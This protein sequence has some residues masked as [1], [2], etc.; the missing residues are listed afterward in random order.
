V[1]SAPSSAAAAGIAVAMAMNS[2]A[3]M[4]TMAMTDREMSR[5]AGSKT[6]RAGSASVSTRVWSPRLLTR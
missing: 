3:T 6:L 1:L 5:Y 2:N 4:V